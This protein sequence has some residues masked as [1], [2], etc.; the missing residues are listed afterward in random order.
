[1]AQNKTL[2]VQPIPLIAN[3]HD[4]PTELRRK[5]PW[6]AAAGAVVG[7]PYM[8]I[9]KIKVINKTATAQ[10]FDMERCH[11]C[12]RSGTEPFINMNVAANSMFVDWRIFRQTPLTSSRWC[13]TLLRH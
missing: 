3:T 7:Q 12:Q 2:N 4:Q 13:I 9:R 10:N 8:I 5:P 6:P 1:M 11:W